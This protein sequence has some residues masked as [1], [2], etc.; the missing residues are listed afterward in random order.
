MRYTSLIL[1]TTLLLALPAMAQQYTTRTGK[2]SFFSGTPV[3]N[4]EAVSNQAAASLDA[5]TGKL[6]VQM[7]IKSFRFKKRLMEEHFNENYMES[8]RYPK[9]VF[10]GRITDMSQADLTKAGSY[11]VTAEGVLTMHGVS[12]DVV[13]PGNLTVADGNVTAAASFIVKPADYK[14]KI[15]S[16][17]RKNIAEEISVTIN[18]VLNEK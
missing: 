3:E 14:I 11:P 12:R 13:I 16:M 4:I 10:D 1:I 17:V 5:G 15:P 18:L 7:L 9:A 6:N 8:D 2:I